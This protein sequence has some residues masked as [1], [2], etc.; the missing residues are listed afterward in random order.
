L[1]PANPVKDM[2]YFAV[3]WANKWRYT[4]AA[5]Q[6]V[7]EKIFEKKAA[8]N[9]QLAISQQAGTWFLVFGTWEALRPS[10]CWDWDWDWVTQASRKGHASVTQASIWIS[11]L[12]ATEIEK[13]RV[14]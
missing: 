4:P 12:F 9:W 1:F 6:G 7:R 8:S 10:A 5:P 2:S 11:G 14:G 13:W 3:E